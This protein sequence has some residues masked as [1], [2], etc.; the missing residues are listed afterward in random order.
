MKQLRGNLINDDN[1]VLEFNLSKEI[2][3]NQEL[4]KL[5]VSYANIPTD[6]T[7]E[8]IIGYKHI[9]SI[10]INGEIHCI[11]SYRHIKDK[12]YL[13]KKL[14]RAFCDKPL[15]QPIGDL[16]V[17]AKLYG[18]R[19]AELVISYSLHKLYLISLPI[20]IEDYVDFRFGFVG[21]KINDN[22]DKVQ[23]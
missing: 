7:K 19:D 15:M 2:S 10:S 20:N 1:F 16:C 18:Y 3:D 9:S 13:L 8:S 14:A 23:L 17:N 4:I 11:E 5:P 22:S 6:K 21:I 12:L